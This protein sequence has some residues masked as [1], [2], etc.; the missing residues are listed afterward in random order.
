MKTAKKISE[1]STSAA[2]QSCGRARDAELRET[3]QQRATSGTANRSPAKPAARVSETEKYSAARSS[4]AMP[5]FCRPRVSRCFQTDCIVPNVQRKRWR[6]SALDGFR[7]FRPADGVFVVEDLPALAAN[8]HGQIGV[9]CDGV[10]RRN[11]RNSRMTS[12]RQAPTRAGH[13]GNAIQQIERALL[14]ILAGD[15]F[16]RLPAREPAIA[17]PHFH[18]AGNGADARDRRNGEPASLIASGSMAVSASIVT[19]IS[20]VAAARP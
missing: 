2:V 13:N 9:F 7:R 16:E 1:R 18:V 10:A 15:V 11:R 6:I 17:V 8:G 4:Q 12:A 20:P 14:E 19:M 5:Y 3:P